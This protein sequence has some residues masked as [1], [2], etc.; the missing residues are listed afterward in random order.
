MIG[1]NSDPP[2]GGMP[3]VSSPRPSVPRSFSSDCSC[4]CAASTSWPRWNTIRP[5]SVSTI[6]RPSR[7]SSGEPISSSSAFT[8][9]L[10]VGCVTNSRSAAAV[11]LC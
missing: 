8:I 11:K 7:S 6:C 3:I 1:V 2:S 9:L 4:A 10:M 5:A